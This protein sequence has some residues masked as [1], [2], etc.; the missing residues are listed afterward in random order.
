[1]DDERVVLDGDDDNLTEHLIAGTC[2]P[3][4]KELTKEED[5]RISKMNF[6]KA[7]PAIVKEYNDAQT[8][9]A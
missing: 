6:L 3:G 9:K 2:P 8:Q 4:Y 5:E 1:M 7:L